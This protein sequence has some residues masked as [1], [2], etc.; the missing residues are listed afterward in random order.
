MRLEALF[1]RFVSRNLQTLALDLC[2]GRP[3]ESFS[4]NKSVT[5]VLWIEMPL[6]VLPVSEAG[7]S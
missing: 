2:D 4:P 3:K 1:S 7:V 6:S 5:K